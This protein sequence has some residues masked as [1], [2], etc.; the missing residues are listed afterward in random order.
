MDCGP[1][2]VDLDSRRE[3]VLLRESAFRPAPSAEDSPFD[4]V[5][6]PFGYNRATRTSAVDFPGHASLVA[7]YALGQD[8]WCFAQPRPVHYQGAR[9]YQ[10]HG[11]CRRRLCLR[12]E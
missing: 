2:L 5:P 8:L 6:L 9:S 12:C 11:Y 3:P 7:L 1:Y 4:L 10:R